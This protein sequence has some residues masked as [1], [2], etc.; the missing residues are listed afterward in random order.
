MKR[1]NQNRGRTPPGIEPTNTNS[2][3]RHRLRLT[4]ALLFG[5]ILLAGIPGEAKAQVPP[6]TNFLQ[7]LSHFQPEDSATAA[8]YYQAVDPL[9]K[10]TTAADWAAN[11]GFVANAANY[12]SKGSPGNP[13]DAEAIANSYSFALYQNAT[14]LGFIRRMFIRVVPSITA[15]N[16]S[17]Y[18][19]VENYF[20]R[21]DLADPYSDARARTNRIATV[22]FEWVP[23]ADG[24][25]PGKKFGT[26]YTFNGN[27]Q[28]AP[29]GVPFAPN[30]DGEGAKQQPG[31]CLVCHGGLPSVT[32]NGV[33]PNKGQIKDFKFLPFDLDNF[34]YDTIDPNLSRAAQENAFRRFN[35]AVLLTHPKTIE[36]DD[37]GV[38]RQTAGRELIEGWYGGPAGVNNLLP[39]HL[40]NGNFT[41]K[42][43]REPVNG[44]TAPVGSEYL[45]QTTLARSCRGCHVQQELSLDL[46]TQPGF[47]TKVDGL[48]D[49][50]LRVQCSADPA[51]APGRRDDRRFMPDALLTYQRFWEN[52][53]Q[54]SA[55]KNYLLSLGI[56]L[57]CP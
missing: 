45:Y 31:V 54:V 18:S 47:M 52:P 10:R 53:A 56:T 22:A 49:L 33:Y 38:R 3:S 9:N 11:A 24:S 44:G 12:V 41:P 17:L 16:P 39:V 7:F 29:G 25:N 26:I 57:P 28:R 2:R 4:H 46:A 19:Y 23:A 13:G 6:G 8:A 5:I 40:F 14:D 20:Y 35:E 32:V 50:V 30:L 21:S 48:K 27:D 51:P 15:K 1:M 42:G 36:A 37:Q 55:L 43:W 34:A